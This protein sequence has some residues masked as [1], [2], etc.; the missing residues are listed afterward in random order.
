MRLA[1]LVAP[2]LCRYKDDFEKKHG[3]RLGFMSAF[4]AASTAALKEVPA[5]NAVID[6]E[7]KEIVYKDYCDVSVAVASPKGLVV[8]VLRN[9]ETMTFKVN[10]TPLPLR[11]CSCELFA[12]A[13]PLLLRAPRALCSCEPLA[14]ASSTSPFLAPAS[15]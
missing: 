3:C 14:P 8:P 13:S 7:T 1:R 12:P 5:I 9:T 11:P 10:A 2:T 15:P 4:V 6:D